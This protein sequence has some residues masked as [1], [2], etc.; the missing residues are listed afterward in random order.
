ML[1]AQM[2]QAER[3]FGNCAVHILYDSSVFS[4]LFYCF[5]ES[6][7][8]LNITLSHQIVGVRK[9]LLRCLIQNPC[10]KQSQ[11]ERGTQDIIE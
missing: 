3:S 11:V 6:S 10:S 7:Y 9:D 5:Q 4:Y 8:V 1:L 2:S